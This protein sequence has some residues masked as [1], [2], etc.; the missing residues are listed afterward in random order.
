MAQ[1]QGQCQYQY[2]AN[3]RSW[4]YLSVGSL[5]F[6]VLLLVLLTVVIPGDNFFSGVKMRQ[7]TVYCAASIRM[8]IEEVA[9]Q[10]EK[11]HGVRIRLDFAS[12][13]A[14]EARLRHDIEQ[15]LQRADIYIPA[16][17]I[18]ARRA[19]ADGLCTESIAF[20]QM[21][22]VFATAHADR[23]S[24]TLDDI[25]QS[26]SIAVCSKNA[27]AGHLLRQVLGAR[28]DAVIRKNTP[29]A[30]T[31]VEAATWIQENKNLDGGFI[32]DVTARQFALQ[33]IP[34]AELKQAYSI[35]SANICSTS[36]DPR[37]ALHFARYLADAHTGGTIFAR[38]H[39]GL[40]QSAL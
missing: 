34:L 2:G 39:F 37:T 22:L 30:A 20:A 28:W 13:G 1:D 19:L 26:L 8:P 36:Q 40:V 31:V 11:E 16:D 23:N 3:T 25:S 6:V 33:I 17:M 32:W 35:I 15:G 14:L 27:A 24:V 29:E 4:A 38:H 18:F 12:S 10:Y 21:Q 5:L 7:L 9:A